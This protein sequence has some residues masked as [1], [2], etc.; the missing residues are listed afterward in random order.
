MHQNPQMAAARG[1]VQ[2][3][4][5]DAAPRP[6][7]IDTNIVLDLL[8][9]ADPS[10]AGVHALLIC[11]Q[12]QWIATRAMREELACVLTYVHLQPHMQ[13]QGKSAAQLLA[14]FDA[15]VQWQ[16]PAAPAPWL[17]LDADD[18]KF[19]DLAAARRAILLSKDKAVLRLRKKLATLDTIVASGISVTTQ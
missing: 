1:I 3:L 5:G 6:V 19:I 17:C 13:R 16:P 4:P 18:Q 12:L 2:R 15:A 14:A 11:G 10:T 9:F 8:L 7:V